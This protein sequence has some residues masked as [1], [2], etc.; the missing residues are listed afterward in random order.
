[1]EGKNRMRVTQHNRGTTMNDAAVL[2]VMYLVIERSYA[3]ANMCVRK[4][5]ER[6]RES[7]VEDYRKWGI[8]RNLV[9]TLRP[10]I[11]WITIR[12]KLLIIHTNTHR[13]A[14][15]RILYKGTLND[16]KR[17]ACLSSSSVYTIKMSINVYFL[18]R[19]VEYLIKQ[20]VLHHTE[21]IV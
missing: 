3:W 16:E 10:W 5:R 15:H 18:R 4:Q 9:I 14:T 12:M 6:E 11:D 8:I 19:P 20:F 17:V 2:S 21:Y 1:M 7:T 13:A